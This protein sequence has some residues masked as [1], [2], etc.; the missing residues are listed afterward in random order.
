MS[1]S[2]SGERGKNIWSRINLDELVGVIAFLGDRI[3]QLRAQTW[4]FNVRT[5]SSISLRGKVINKLQL[6]HDC[7]ELFQYV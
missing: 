6:D 1:N 7:Y 3:E 4:Q 5:R 2:N